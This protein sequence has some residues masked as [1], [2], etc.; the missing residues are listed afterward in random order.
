MKE[1]QGISDQAIIALDS[2]NL[3]RHEQ[4]SRLERLVDRNHELLRLLD[5]SHSAL[6]AIKIKASQEPFGLHTKLTGAGG[7]GCAVTVVPDGESTFVLKANSIGSILTT[8]SGVF[9]DFPEEKLQQLRA[10][11]H[12]DG[13]ACY[14]TAVGG[15][16]VGVLPL[17]N[18]SGESSTHV[19]GEAGAEEDVLPL[20][21]QFKNVQGGKLAELG[22]SLGKWAYA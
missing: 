2:D 7:G 1:I 20:V 17:P 18:R 16:G 5:V 14:E 9:V 6:E 13:F 15:S 8:T 21:E 11:L 3:S 22:D 4:I 19:S 10:E 12:S